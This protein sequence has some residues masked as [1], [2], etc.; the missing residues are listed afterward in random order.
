[1]S[2]EGRWLRW[3]DVR[4]RSKECGHRQTVTLPAD[5]RLGPM[6]GK[7]DQC[8]ERERLAKVIHS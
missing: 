2:G 4:S 3:F 1:M 8:I 7:C 6:P 5:T